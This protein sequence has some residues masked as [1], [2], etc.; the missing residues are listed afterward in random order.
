M[1]AAE[2]RAT[3]SRGGAG[4]NGVLLR[5]GA[6]VGFENM[7]I[8]RTMAAGVALLAVAGAARGQALR[9]GARAAGWA[10]SEPAAGAAYAYEALPEEGHARPAL[11]RIPGGSFAMGNSYSNLYPNEGYAQELPVHEVP[12]SEFFIGRFEFTNEELAR[13]LQWALT[14]G[15]AEL[16][17][18]VTTNVAGG[19]TN[20][21]TNLYGTVRNAEG[22][23]R[24]LVDLDDPLCQVAYTNGAFAVAA[25]KT[26]F[27][28]ICVTW[29]GAQ[30]LGNY[31]SDREGLARA[32]DFAPE[33]WTVDLAAEGYRLPTEAEWE[34]AARGGNP[35][36]HFPWPDDSAQG[37]N[38][39][40]YSIDPA[41]A[42]YWDGRYA[43]SDS[44]L[45]NHPMHP[46]FA[47]AVRTTPAGYYDGGQVI[48]NFSTNVA[49][50]G[51][52]FGATND[53]ANGYGLH[54]MAGNVYEWCGDYHGT[55]WYAQAGATLPD[56][57]GPAAAESF[58][59]QRVVRGGGWLIYSLLQP[60]DPS[61]QR[62]SFRTSF[63]AGWAD[64]F[65]GFRVA[66]RPTAY[67]AWALGEGLDPLGAD[68]A[69]GEDYDDDGQVN[70]AER[71]AGTQPTNAESLF[72][73]TGVGPVSNAAPVAHWGVSGRVYVV[74]GATNLP[75]AGDWQVLAE[76][77]NAATG[78]AWIPVDAGPEF[79]ALRIRAR[80]A[81]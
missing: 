7:T 19:V 71:V 28:A 49:Y 40:L 43:M 47:E 38:L 20:V 55:G 58:H 32:V 51:A 60:P 74:E 63:P 4:K 70:G 18:T 59:T 10:P 39:Y 8:G 33:D 1:H 6:M 79:R 36:T 57:A 17:P 81:P 77:T 56:P 3:G 66:R 61:F 27:P 22:T 68:G 11:A 72:K 16:G 25:G 31:L 30:A 80:M 54:D 64:T 35:G 48:T 67:E 21:A 65:L 26:N 46:W 78:E 42:N 23:P 76:V 37:T 62:C 9:G 73:V 5:S 14:N 52:D 12:V 41:K 15:L 50:R 24:E 34:K 44:Q 53:M 69:A 13:T 75:A 29:H 45:T 2:R